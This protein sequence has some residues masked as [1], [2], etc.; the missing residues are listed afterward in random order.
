MESSKR[1]RSEMEEVDAG[2]T[3]TGNQDLYIALKVP[4]KSDCH[5][6]VVVASNV[7][8]QWIKQANEAWAAEI[9]KDRHVRVEIGNYK[10][11]G[12]KG[13]IPTYK[14]RFAE[15]E[16]QKRMENFYRVFYRAP[17]G[18]R[19]YPNAKFHITV[20]NPERLAEI[21]SYSRDNKSIIIDL[22]ED[23]IVEVRAHVPDGESA[24]VD[25]STWKC[26][27]CN[28][29]N[30]LSHKECFGKDKNGKLCTQWRP[31][32][33]LDQIRNSR[34]YD[35]IWVDNNNNEDEDGS[36]SSWK[37]MGCCASN[38]ASRDSCRMCHIPKLSKVSELPEWT[39]NVSAVAHATQEVP[40]E[41]LL[42]YLGPSLD[43]QYQ[44]QIQKD[45]ING[46]PTATL[47]AYPAPF[48]CKKCNNITMGREECLMCFEPHRK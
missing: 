37:C 11:L 34:A 9:V 10:L 35:K 15:P 41:R 14:C 8:S 3:T 40:D 22:S 21:E 13:T 38:Y 23:I 42:N 47:K 2:T 32:K 45:R 31:K 20:D 7:T 4:G 6:T 5:I 17:V 44:Q 48:K 28:N 12:D 1:G 24:E 46:R 43:V 33:V 16:L 30:P 26:V 27:L 25:D 29:R 19:M 36:R 18:E 39:R